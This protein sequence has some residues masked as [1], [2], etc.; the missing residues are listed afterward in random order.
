[1]DTTRRPIHEGAGNRFDGDRKTGRWWSAR[2]ER[3]FV[4]RNLSRVPRWLETYHLTLLTLAWSGLALSCGA[5]AATQDPRWLWGLHVAIVG[6]YLSDLFDGAVGRARGTGLVRWGF[7]M[8][9]LLDFVFL[10]ALWLAY[11]WVLPTT[12]LPWLALLLALSGTAM[13]HSFLAFGATGEFRISHAGFGPTETRIALLGLNTAVVTWGA[14]WL[15]VV[16]PWLCLGAAAALAL[17]VFQTQRALWQR[18]LAT[19]AAARG[20]DSGML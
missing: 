11:L 10:A 1:M 9:H 4:R 8:D 18:D 3:R 19:K 20:D 7:Y 17:I 12:A 14:P 5:L 16:L 6:Q 15:A 13:A 2:V